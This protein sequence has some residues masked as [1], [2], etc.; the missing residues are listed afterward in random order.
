[1]RI[2]RRS[3][4]FVAALWDKGVPASQITLLVRVTSNRFH[5]LKRRCGRVGRTPMLSFHTDPEVLHAISRKTQENAGGPSANAE[6]SHVA[7]GARFSG[8]R[9]I[10]ARRRS[11]A[12][13]VATTTLEF[14]R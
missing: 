3:Y 2:V 1:M 12:T 14:V 8:C 7:R 4:L 13:N 5:E 9:S 6:G 11:E 10:G